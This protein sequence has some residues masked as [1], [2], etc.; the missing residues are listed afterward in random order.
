MN[1]IQLHPIVELRRFCAGCLRAIRR[2]PH[3]DAELMF[4]GAKQIADELAA[5]RIER[6][7]RL[8]AQIAKAQASDSPGGRNITP[9]EIAPV[10]SEAGGT[11]ALIESDAKA[12]VA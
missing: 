8:Q 3:V 10:I 1:A 9:A 2:T 11:V 12:K 6:E 4:D 7:Q 5:E